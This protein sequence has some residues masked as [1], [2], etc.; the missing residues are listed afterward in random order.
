MSVP[1]KSR[2]NIRS[3]VK[4]LNINKTTVHRFVKWGKIKRHNN[5]IKPSLTSHNKLERLRWCLK[6][7]ILG[8]INTIPRFKDMYNMVH[9]DE[10]WF[11][12]SKTSQCF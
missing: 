3:L 6:H 4:A 2:S 12:M 11:F 7:I 9:V 1:L 5:A 8:T 10:K